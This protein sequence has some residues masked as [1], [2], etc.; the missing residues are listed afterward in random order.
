MLLMDKE[1]DSFNGESPGTKVTQVTICWPMWSAA[2]LNILSPSPGSHRG[3]TLYR[4]VP[5]KERI[6]CTE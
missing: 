6:Q 1:E 2:L 4:M 3:T 5:F